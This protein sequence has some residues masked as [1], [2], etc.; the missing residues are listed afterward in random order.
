MQPY[1]NFREEMTEY[2]GLLF[3]GSR[4]VIPENLWKEYM[5][6]LHKGH[7]GIENCLRKAKECV[8]WPSMTQQM[9]EMYIVARFFWFY[10]L[11]F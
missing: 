1:F 11:F 9:T 6:Q 5:P 7:G 3:K 10:I 2:E 8:F 4:V